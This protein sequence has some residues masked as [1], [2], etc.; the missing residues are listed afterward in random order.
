MKST[1]AVENAKMTPRQ[2]WILAV[3][4]TLALLALLPAIAQA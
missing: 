2:L 4:W 1:C 3:V